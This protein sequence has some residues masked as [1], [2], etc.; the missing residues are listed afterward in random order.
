MSYSKA[1]ADFLESRNFKD[2]EYKTNE[3]LATHCTFKIGGNADFWI[4]PKTYTAAKDIIFAANESNVRCTVIGNGS[5]ILFSSEG[6]RGAVICTS[7][8][9][10]ISVK[11]KEISCKAGT[12]LSRLAASAIKSSLTG[13]E[14]AYGIPGSVGGAVYMNAGAY[15][16]EISAV[17]KESEYFDPSDGRIKTLTNAEHSFS[18]RHSVFIGSPYVILKSVFALNSGDAV[19]IKAKM[20]E[21]MAKRREKQPLEYPS[22]GSVFKRYPGFYTA[23]LIDEA[24]LKGYRIGGAEI[25]TKHAGFIINTGGAI[26]DDVLS[27]V[28][29]IKEKIYKL[30]NIK[31]ETEIRYIV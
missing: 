31:I 18:Y 2:L 15:E 26:S 16:G 9:C 11:G 5:N 27:L 6:Y 7:K 19:E 21:L 23:R 4:L 12:P 22:A 13:L 25:S 10:G 3:S 8:L 17:L 14:W 29:L 24:G 30:Y 1:F 20:D 28:E